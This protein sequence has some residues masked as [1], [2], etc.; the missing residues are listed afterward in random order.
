MN[1]SFDRYRVGAQVYNIKCWGRLRSMIDAGSGVHGD[2]RTSKMLIKSKPVLSSEVEQYH[3]EKW[4]NPLLLRHWTGSRG[5]QTFRRIIGPIAEGAGRHV[6]HERGTCTKQ[7]NM[8]AC[9][10]DVECIN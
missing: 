8:K 6:Q 9:R 2:P 7:S 10:F 4:N 3:G 1:G 5:D